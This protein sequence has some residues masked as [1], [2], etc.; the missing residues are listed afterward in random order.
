[1]VRG[2]KYS[3]RYYFEFEVD[4]LRAACFCFLCSLVGAAGLSSGDNRQEEEEQARAQS[5]EEA[6]Q[7]SYG[8]A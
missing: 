2:S 7:V 3:S 5:L 8:A 1:M 4:W 6:E